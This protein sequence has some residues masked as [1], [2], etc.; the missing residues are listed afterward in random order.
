LPK[1]TAAKTA[2]QFDQASNGRFI[3]GLGVANSVMNER[4]GIA[5]FAPLAMIEEYAAVVRAVLAGNPTGYDGQVFRT[6]M[7]PLDSPPIRTELPIYLAA[8][9][10]RMFELAGRIAD[11]VILNLMTPAQAGAAVSPRRRG[12]SAN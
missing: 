2:A 3:L 5:P 10:P 12:C 4:F 11:G 7:V 9:G 6:G 8:L 1:G